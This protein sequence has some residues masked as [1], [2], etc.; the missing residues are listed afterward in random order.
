MLNKVQTVIKLGLSKDS[1]ALNDT[2]GYFFSNCILVHAE[3][4]ATPQSSDF[5]GSVFFNCILNSKFKHERNITCSDCE[6]VD[7]PYVRF[8]DEIMRMNDFS[9]LDL[10]CSQSENTT[11][12]SSKFNNSNVSNSFFCSNTFFSCNFR[13]SNLKGV[14]FKD[15]SFSG[16]NFIDCEYDTQT[17]FDSCTFNTVFC[18]TDLVPHLPYG[19]DTKGVHILKPGFTL[20]G[21]KFA[22]DLLLNDMSLESSE[23]RGAHLSGCVFNRVNLRSSN[24]S[25]GRLSSCCFKNSYLSNSKF[26][27]CNFQLVIFENVEL[28]NCEFKLMF[29]SGCTSISNS[30]FSG[31]I[32]DDCTF[33]GTESASRC[34]F[35]NCEFLEFLKFSRNTTFVDCDFTKSKI[36]ECINAVEGAELLKCNFSY[37]DLSRNKLLRYISFLESVFYE[38]NLSN[39]SFSYCNMKSCDLRNA[40]LSDSN[41]YGVSFLDSDLTGAN[42][43]N[44]DLAMSK[45]NSNTKG[46]SDSQKSKMIFVDQS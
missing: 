12:Y 18:T 37:A 31:S 30:N 11:F 34:S 15:S 16:C 44:T 41:F 25:E 39:C 29:F 20:I 19:E 14:V 26:S 4:F 13:K 43:T 38:A 5:S 36:I 42:F 9:N 27:S 2:R 35:K 23:I 17:T 33:E 46:L 24:F 45:Y 1:A 6:F 3:T 28:P 7:E 8:N 22:R 40:N 32:F 21:N 10:E